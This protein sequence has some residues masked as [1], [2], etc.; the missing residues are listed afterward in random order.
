MWPH[1]KKKKKLPYLFYKLHNLPKMM[2][3]KQTNKNTTNIGYNYLYRRLM[4]SMLSIET[5]N[6]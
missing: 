6:W 4:K 3:S 5:L 1:A 2:I